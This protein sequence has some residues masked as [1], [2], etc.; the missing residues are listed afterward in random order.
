LIT[1][2]LYREWVVGL[3]TKN[4]PKERAPNGN[5]GKKNF[6]SRMPYP[7]PLECALTKTRGRTSAVAATVAFSAGSPNNERV[8][9]AEVVSG[10][11]EYLKLITEN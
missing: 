8:A 1:I 6:E 10:A 5:L 7:S 3:L 4:L 9:Q 2:Q 11:V